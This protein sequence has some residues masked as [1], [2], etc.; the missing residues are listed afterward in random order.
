MNW[1][2]TLTGSLRCDSCESGKEPSCFQKENFKEMS[3]IIQTEICVFENGS[4]DTVNI[5]WSPC[6]VRMRYVF[7]YIYKFI[8]NT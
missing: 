3:N 6:V 7:V 1:M 4:T 2:K 5:A 8:L